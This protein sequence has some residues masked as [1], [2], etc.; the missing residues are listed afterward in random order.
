MK[1]I[2]AFFR[3]VHLTIALVS[4]LMVNGQQQ[5]SDFDPAS[6]LEQHI[7][8]Q[9]LER[10]YVHIDK[11]FYATGETIWFKTYLVDGTTHRKSDRSRLV[12][13]DLLNQ[14]DSLVARKKIYVE[15]LGANGDIFLDEKLEQGTYTLRAYTRYMLNEKQPLFFE[16]KIPIWAQGAMP[17][18]TKDNASVQVLEELDLAEN[19]VATLHFFPKA[20]I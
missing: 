1:P 6:A 7:A 9:G 18:P 12:Y 13:V 20:V 16:K 3:R 8:H 4:L 19:S 10:A 5:V 2:Y 15:H 11:D 17:N 14:A